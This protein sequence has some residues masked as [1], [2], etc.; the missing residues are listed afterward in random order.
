[1]LQS[2]K[3]PNHPKSRDES[4]EVP[5]R[6]YFWICKDTKESIMT[7]IL[8]VSTGGTFNKIYNPLTGSLDVDTDAKAL[9]SIAD[10]W[11]CNLEIET[12]IGKDS[13]D[14]DDSDRQQLAKTILQSSQKKIIVVHGTDTMDLSAQALAI[15]KISKTIVLTGSMVPYSIDPTEATA[16][17]ASAIGY[18]I[19]LS[20]NGVYIAMNGQL[21]KYNQITK[22]RNRGKFITTTLQ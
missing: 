13:L 4:L 11:L 15:L 22:D 12:I 19:A 6:L 10:K 14:M 20:E 1:M 9:R 8:I 18:A 7:D 3:T 16:N 5:I 17:L 21:G 2:T